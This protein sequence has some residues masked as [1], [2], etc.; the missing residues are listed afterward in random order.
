M[1]WTGLTEFN[2]SFLSLESVCVPSPKAPRLLSNL[3]T[4]LPD[5]LLWGCTSATFSHHCRGR[6]H[7]WSPPFVV[8]WEVVQRCFSSFFTIIFLCYPP[9]IYQ[10]HNQTCILNLCPANLGW[11]TWVSVQFWT[12]LQK[13]KS[14]YAASDRNLWSQ[15]RTWTF[16]G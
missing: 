10:R 4:A 11:Y 3:T 7:L 16:L 1:T 6:F 14:K 15:Q 5:V 2:V 12:N 13:N 8:P 9:R